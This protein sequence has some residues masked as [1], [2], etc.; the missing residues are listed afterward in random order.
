V[1]DRASSRVNVM[2]A[3]IARVGRSAHD[4]MMLGQRFALLTIDAFRV[5]AIAKPFKAGSVIREL[6]LEVFQC[7][8]EHFRLAVVMGHWVTY[9]QVKPYQTALPTVKG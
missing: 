1:E 4:A 3:M 5:Q 6:L 9:C 2:A 7:V 8:R